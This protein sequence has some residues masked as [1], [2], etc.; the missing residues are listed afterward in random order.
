MFKKIGIA[1]CSVLLV[2]SLSAD[3]SEAAEMFQ[4][5][6]CMSCH[7]VEDFKADPKKTK[8]FHKLHTSVQACQQANDA[9]W[10][11]DETLE[12]TKYLN[13]KYYHFKETAE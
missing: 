4:E 2:S 7:N 11:D 6:D 10:F 9:G 13:K 8:D 5:A 3:D 12:V 1:L